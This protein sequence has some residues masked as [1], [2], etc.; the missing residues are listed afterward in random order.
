MAGQCQFVVQGWRFQDLTIF[1]PWQDL[2]RPWL[3]HVSWQPRNTNVTFG[4]LLWVGHVLVESC[5]VIEPAYPSKL[6]VFSHAQH[7]C[8]WQPSVGRCHKL[9]GFWVLVLDWVLSW[10]FEYF[11]CALYTA[12]LW[13]KFFGFAWPP[14]VCQYIFTNL[15]GVELELSQRVWT[16]QKQSSTGLERSR[17]KCALQACIKLFCAWGPCSRLQY[18]LPIPWKSSAGKSLH[19]NDYQPTLA[20]HGC[21]RI[22]RLVPEAWRRP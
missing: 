15:N 6:S 7:F 18:S 1:N 17:W 21:N 2:S 8:T 4:G 10:L 5:W 13:N 16:S 11:C 19:S 9:F 14:S 3:W 20:R 22:S 12:M